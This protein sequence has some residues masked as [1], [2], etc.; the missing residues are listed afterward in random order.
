MAAVLPELPFAFKAL[1][2]QGETDD[3]TQHAV[4]VVARRITHRSRL[5]PLGFV[6]TAE[7]ADP[8]QQAFG[9][10]EHFGAAMGLHT[11]VISGWHY[12][13]VLGLG[14]VPRRADIGFRT[15]KDHQRRAAVHQIAPLWV[16]LGEVAVQ[17]AI[18]PFVCFQQQR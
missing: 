18:G 14:S 11:D 12:L 2:G 4:D 10:I 6:L 9:V 8:L 3:G 1:N 7:A 16:G 15:L 5:W 13:A 17:R